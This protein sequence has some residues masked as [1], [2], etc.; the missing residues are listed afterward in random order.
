MIALL[1]RYPIPT[2]FYS[3]L[4]AVIAGLNLTG[5]G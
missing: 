5:H 2:A 1:R 3:F 4:A